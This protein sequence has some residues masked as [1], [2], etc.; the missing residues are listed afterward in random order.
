MKGSSEFTNFDDDNSCVSG[1]IIDAE[2]ENH[3]ANSNGPGSHRI[4][5]SGL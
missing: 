2:V 1:A 3:D 4:R 5:R